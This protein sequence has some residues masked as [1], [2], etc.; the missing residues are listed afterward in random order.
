MKRR[1]FLQSGSAAVATALVGCGGG[2]GGS[3]SDAAVAAGTSADTATGTTV[4]TASAA[5]TGPANLASPANPASP[6]T[7][8]TSSSA[9][10]QQQAT[11]TVPGIAYPFGSRLTPYVA[12]ILPNNASNAQMDAKIKSFYDAW[13]P[14]IVS[15]PTIPGGKALRFS[16]SYITVSEGMGYG[17]LITVIMAG[18]DANARAT[19]D[20]LLTTVRARPA[21]GIPSGSGGPYLMD[22]RLDASGNS[23]GD[24]WNAMD[25]DLDI[26][27]ALLMADKQWGSTGTWNY[28]QEA[29]NTIGALKAWNMKAD[30]TTKGLPSANNNRTSDYMVSHF[31]AFK[32][33][34]GDS[35][36][37]L[38]VDRAYWLLDNIQTT[39][40]PNCGLM[41]DFIINTNT[42]TP[43]PSQGY[44]G[45]G[46]STEGYYFAN[47]ERNPWRLGTDF[48][49]TGD[50][51]FKTICQRLTTFMQ[52]DCGG[53][54][55]SLSIGYHLDGSS[56]GHSWAPTAIAGPLQCGAMVDA[57]FQPFLNS[58]WTWTSSNFVTSY[59]DSELM[60]IPMIVASGNWWTT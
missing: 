1:I 30:G 20:A 60:L 18:Y 2:G 48:V 40:S 26:A 13:K 17:M 59:Y 54:P 15:V 6:T 28:K 35:V 39:Y 41:P 47:A 34:T 14:N 37:D 8:T 7:A 31:R 42:S 19:F 29:L 44:I 55:G 50:T 24:G 27:M 9:P 52:K 4:T 45:D 56:M 21:Y 51:R 58:L 25:G 43:A 12:G 33:A 3:S 16:S 10:A 36:W 38:A 23:A 46:T 53:S 11:S 57:S 22:W 5:P 49:L 32:R